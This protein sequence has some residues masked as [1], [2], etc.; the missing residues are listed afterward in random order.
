M[1]WQRVDYMD[2]KRIRSIMGWSHHV[3]DGWTISMRLEAA[4]EDLMESWMTDIQIDYI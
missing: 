3:L 4:I 1:G 2:Y